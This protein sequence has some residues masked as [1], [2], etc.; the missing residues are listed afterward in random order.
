M[1]K[2]KWLLALGI[3]F[4]G[5]SLKAE[6]AIDFGRDLE[7]Q[8][9]IQIQRE[10]RW[11]KSGAGAQE[12]S[13]AVTD[14][15]L[16]NPKGTVVIVHGIL[17]HSGRYRYISEYLLGQGY[18]VVLFDLRGHGKSQGERA[19]VDSFD[20]YWK[21]LDA[22]IAATLAKTRENQVYVL[23][24]SM[25]G[26]ISFLH[27]ALSPQNQKVKAYLLSSPGLAVNLTPLEKLKV[28]FGRF[29]P[30][31][32]RQ[33]LS[34]TSEDLVS[35]PDEV[36]RMNADSMVLKDFSTKLGLELVAK[37][38]AAIHYAAKWNHPLFVGSSENDKL[39]NNAGNTQLFGQISR[40]VDINTQIYPKT[41][42]EIFNSEKSVRENIF[43]DY[44]SFLE[45]H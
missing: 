2:L 3:S 39:I 6:M 17:E 10:A 11:V 27:G 12:V 8:G 33:K 5:L 40:S 21:D 32:S 18:S 41:K 29:I 7:A 36:K 15:L 22:V 43:K 23:G 24:H 13:I 35:T 19:Y 34:T 37:T 28:F 4:V 9:G 31:H 26:L 30:K 16:P 1:E 42:H 25:G 20:Q 45:K 14:L 44:L 38:K